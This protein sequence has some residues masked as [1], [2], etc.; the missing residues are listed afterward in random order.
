[1]L[2]LLT[3][4]TATFAQENKESG[5]YFGAIIGT[6][7]ND[8]NRHFNVDLD[9]QLYSF[10]IGAGSSWTK[11]NYVIGFEFVYSAAQKD[12]QAGQIQYIGFS[13]MLSF[14]YNITRSKTWK[15]E[16]NIGIVIN[17]NQLI[18]QDKLGTT[19]Q[20]LTNNP[21][22]G[23]LGLNIK[24]QGN[25]GLFTGVKLGYIMPF[26]GETEWKN[27][28]ADTNSNLKDNLGTFYLQLNIGGLLKLS[29]N[30]SL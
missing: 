17:N 6:K 11:N 8:F 23:N 30:T 28:V 4:S 21:I 1:M 18:V 10:S 7:I 16:P 12:N 19:F 13:N 22:S 29:K 27:T 9:P 14:G 24:L 2:G 15:V 25:N 26:A 3:I 20:N 5:M